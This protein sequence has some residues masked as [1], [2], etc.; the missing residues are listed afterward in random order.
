MRKSTIRFGIH[1]V[2]AA[3]SLITLATFFHDPIARVF[4]F[5][6]S[7]ETRFVFLALGWG[8]AIGCSGILFAA[9]G[10]FRDERN[11]RDPVNLIP[12]MLILIAAIVVFFALLFSSFDGS[13]PPGA[14][15]GETVII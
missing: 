12:S 7:A 1:L 6:A 13:R 3:I 8:G 14:H 5:S 10:L 2:T 4:S 9:S 15:P 11:L